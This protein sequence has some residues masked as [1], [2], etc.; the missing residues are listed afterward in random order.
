[1]SNEFWWGVGAT[2]GVLLA[3][4]L[5]YGLLVL[6]LRWLDNNIDERA[7][8]RVRYLTAQTSHDVSRYGYEI[9]A[10]DQ[11]VLDLRHLVGQHDDRL[12]SRAVDP[13][14]P[15]VPETPS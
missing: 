9:K 4:L 12:F 14:P 3:L 5:A 11:A 15:R 8:G 2:L 10:L 13:D 7:D 1:M 6:A